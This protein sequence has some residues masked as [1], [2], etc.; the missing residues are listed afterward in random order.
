MTGRSWHRGCPVG[1]DGLRLIQLRYWGFDGT[2]HWGQLVVNADSVTVLV[3]AVR[4][5]FEHR[6]PI[7]QMRLVDVF[8]AD[9]EK[10]MAADN[11]S[12]FNCRLVP[13]TAVWSQHA[14]GR[15]VDVNP[16]ENPEVVNGQVDPPSSAPWADRSRSVPGMI[17][18]GDP[19]W[20][21]FVAV[22]WKWGG[23]WNSPKDYQHFSANGL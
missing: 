23:D 17:H 16:L 20:N 11:T 19:T 4:S 15:A 9:D 3:R 5:L 10:S 1:L 18:H 12:A 14:F 8:G 2:A 6:Y 22:G 7:R 21:A 13:G